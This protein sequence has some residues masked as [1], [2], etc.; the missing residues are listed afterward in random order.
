MNN[1]TQQSITQWADQTFGRVHSDIEIA[2]R[3][4]QE[5]GEL[6]KELAMN[7]NSEKA[8]DEIADIVIVL[9]RLVEYRGLDLQQLIN[10]KMAVNRQRQWKLDGSGQG[11]HV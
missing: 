11:Y 7:D 9:Y 5:M 3:A 10:I 6:L 1:E 4:N 2:A 8:M